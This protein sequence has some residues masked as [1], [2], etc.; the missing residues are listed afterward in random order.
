M[1]NLPELAAAVTYYGTP[2]PPLDQLDLIQAS[3]LAIYAELDRALSL[4]M[5]D[6]MSGMLTRQ[7]AFA[8]R[9][10]EDVGH[11]FHNDTVPAYN[12]SAACD[13]WT[14]TL[15]WFNKFLRR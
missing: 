4:R 10:Y 2:T 3:V 1:L 13:A 11:A 6:V 9:L 14:Q 15:G 12:A 8:F 5:P 7:K